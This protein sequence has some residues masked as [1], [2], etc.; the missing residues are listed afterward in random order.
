MKQTISYCLIYIFSHLFCNEPPAFEFSI[1][2]ASVC[3]YA[4]FWKRLG[5]SSRGIRNCSSHWEVTNRASFHQPRIM[6]ATLFRKKNR[7]RALF[8]L[9]ALHLILLECEFELK[10]TRLD[11]P[12][13][14]LRRK[15]L[16]L[17]IFFKSVKSHS[18]L[19][20]LNLCCLLVAA[21]RPDA[22]DKPLF[23]IT[24]ISHSVQL[25]DHLL[26]F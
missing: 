3:K 5:T 8:L 24:S 4:S 15:H 12:I 7:T 6:C 13:W 17:M 9:T 16:C 21:T 18:H 22:R 11:K 2:D 19:F 23:N 14:N 10:H 25:F 1:G 20:N 26:T